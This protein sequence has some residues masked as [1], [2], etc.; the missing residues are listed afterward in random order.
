ML[1]L[2]V[3]NKCSKDM[4][5]PQIRYALL[6][7]IFG[8]PVLGNYHISFTLA[9]TRMF[10]DLGL[11]AARG[12][13]RSA[14]ECGKGR[15]DKFLPKSIYMAQGPTCSLLVAFDRQLVTA[16]GVYTFMSNISPTGGACPSL[17]N[18]GI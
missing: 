17:E 2:V 6:E 11:G 9:L 13:D 14:T 4:G 3:T 18:L 10:F 5:S 1:S 15:A 7:S 16:S 8:H 12:S